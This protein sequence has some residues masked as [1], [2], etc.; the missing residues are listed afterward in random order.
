MYNLKNIL[1][2]LALFLTMALQPSL[3]K[4]NDNFPRANNAAE[5]HWQP[6]SNALQSYG[7]LYLTDDT[8][9]WV[10]GPM[11]KYS[12]MSVTGD[13]KLI[14]FYDVVKLDNRVFR[15]LSIKMIRDNLVIVF[16]ENDYDLDNN[17]SPVSGSYK[18]TIDGLE[19]SQVAARKKLANE[20]KL[21]RNYAKPK[22]DTEE[23]TSNKS[24]TYA[25]EV[26]INLKSGGISEPFIYGTTNLPNGYQLSANVW[27]KEPP[28]GWAT[29]ITVKNGKFKLGPLNKEPTFFVGSSYSV[30]WPFSPGLF[31]VQIFSIGVLTKQSKSVEA[32]VGVLGHNLSGPLVSERTDPLSQKTFRF[33]EYNTY[34]L[35]VG[36]K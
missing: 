24:S 25:L 15:Y 16:Y 19:N 18:S 30:W 2:T 3:A 35:A 31:N 5:A 29:E 28:Y 23:A 17:I 7:D 20:A 26:Y 21:S 6:T 12:V 11:S 33:V 34:N 8:I 10:N 36:Y 13:R 1:T 27:R 4:G 14:E 32:I 22:T 9:R